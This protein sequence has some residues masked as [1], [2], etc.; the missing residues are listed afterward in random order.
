MT[1]RNLDSASA[2]PLRDSARQA[3]VAALELPSADPSRL[4]S[5]AMEVRAH[6]EHAR[7]IVASF[8][9]SRSSE[10][11][12]TSS[13]S[14]AIAM[15]IRG[16]LAKGGPGTVVVGSAVEHSAV[17]ESAGEDF[18]SVPVDSQGIVDVDAFEAMLESEPL[19]ALAACQ[20]GNHEMGAIQPI[21]A[22]AERCA[23]HG[24]MLLVDAA[25]AAPWL[26]INFLSSGAD[27]MA[28][29]GPKLGG[30]PG[31]GALVVKRGKRIPPMVVGGAQERGRRAGLEN[32]PSMMGLA[33]ACE[34]LE[35][36]LDSE[37][38]AALALTD[39]L[40]TGLTAIDGI[41]IFGPDEP[42]DRLPHLVCCGIEGIEPQ[43]VL[44]GLDQR[45][46]SAHSGSACAAEDIQPSPVLEAMGVDAARS[47]RFSVHAN[48][49]ADDI[50]AVLTE[51]PQIVSDLR[52]LA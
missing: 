1:R 36:S 29:S 2:A 39:R 11:I 50:D 21:E 41:T 5:E 8:I 30:P 27:F 9:G 40:R 48:S 24:V 51:L 4:H 33:A 47:L 52:A 12:F 18:R 17:R 28:L 42:D 6:L 37:I 31:T 25:Q 7:E 14:E 3:M 46:I 10:V 43:A 20:W 23:A 49:T 22:I 38:T 16:A 45:G 44:L 26:R 15:T 32:T 35:E 19:I 13:A 34:E